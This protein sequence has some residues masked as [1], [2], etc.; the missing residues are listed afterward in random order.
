MSATAEALQLMRF[1]AKIEKTLFRE[2]E[3]IK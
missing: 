2:A 1:N 3:Q